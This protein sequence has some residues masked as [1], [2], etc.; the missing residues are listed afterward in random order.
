MITIK[1]KA[2][3]KKFGF[4][5]HDLEDFNREALA[6]GIPPGAQVKATVGFKGQITSLEV[7]G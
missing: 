2:D 3:S 1:R 7:S 6:A 5:R 4:C